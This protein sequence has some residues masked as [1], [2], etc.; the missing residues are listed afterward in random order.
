[1]LEHLDEPLPLAKLSEISDL[2]PFHLQRKFK[3][4][5]GIT[6]REYVEQQRMERL[7]TAMRSGLSVT[8]A[9]YEAGFGSSSR[10]YERTAAHLGMTPK[11]YREGGNLQIIRYAFHSTSI[12]LLLVA[13][14]DKG[15]CSIQFGDSDGDLLKNLQAEFSHATLIADSDRLKPHLESVSEWLAGQSV[16]LDLP[17][18]VRATVFQRRV[19]QYL[20]QIPYGTT[21][22][23][24]EIAADLGNPN[25][26]R[27]VARA[28]ATNPV[29]LVI[30]CHR[31][32]RQDGNMAGYRWGIAR[33]ESLLKLERGNS[34]SRRVSM[35]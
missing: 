8:D 3:A 5:L 17:L 19:W 23:Y 34:Q 9:V 27:A 4:I 14:T 21:R 10:V 26:T 2:S 35:D 25:A 15:I 33:K 11:A 24:S 29:S 32:V 6:P 16:S 22:S 13:A 12:G 28:C 30:P 31:V 7:K 18:D 1:M 20:Q